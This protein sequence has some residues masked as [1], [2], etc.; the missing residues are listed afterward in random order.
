M[1][2]LDLKDITI[3]SKIVGI[4]DELIAKDI[5]K[6]IIELKDNTFILNYLHSKYGITNKG[7]SLKRKFNLLL[8]EYIIHNFYQEFLYFC[9]KNK[10]TIFNEDLD[11]TKECSSYARIIFIVFLREIF[12]Y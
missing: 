6:L 8:R 12:H 9:N 4:N 5:I 3:P 10:I 2:L 7:Q 11:I 1:N